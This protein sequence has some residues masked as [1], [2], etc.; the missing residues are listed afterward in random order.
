M[1]AFVPGPDGGVVLAEVAEPVQRPGEALVKVAAYSV[2]RGE[3]L[4]LAGR[5]GRPGGDWR[6]G[7]DVA[8]L[9]VQAAPELTQCAVL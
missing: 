2:N 6:P 4:Q 3:H 1:K 9:V 7:K 8:G 5:L